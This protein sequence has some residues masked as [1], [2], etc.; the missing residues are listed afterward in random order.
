MGQ[1]NRFLMH[2]A[3]RQHGEFT[4]TAARDQVVG[5]RIIGASALQLL[6]DGLEQLVGTLTA[7]ALVEPGEVFDSQQ[8]QVA[9]PGFFDIADLCI[10][11]HFEITPIGQACEA[12][13]IGLNTQLFAALSLLLEQRLELLDHLIHG[14]DHPAQ[15]WGARQVRQA[16]KLATSNG[17]GLRHHV[18]Q[19]LELPT[20]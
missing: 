11:L 2:Q 6:A 12:V 15:L 19:R 18:V 4:A 9:R 5:L 13:L 3:W 16:E 10:E 14:L 20:Q 1:L 8:Q 17:V 7:E